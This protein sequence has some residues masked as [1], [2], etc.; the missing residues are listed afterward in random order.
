MIRGLDDQLASSSR[1]VGSWPNTP[2]VLA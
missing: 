1:Q 2:T